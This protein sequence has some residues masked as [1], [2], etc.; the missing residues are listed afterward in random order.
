MVHAGDATGIITITQ[1]QPI[2]VLFTLPQ[3]SLP[4]HQ[5]GDGRPAS[6]R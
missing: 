4:T 2:S 6:C 3:D 1:I 5:P